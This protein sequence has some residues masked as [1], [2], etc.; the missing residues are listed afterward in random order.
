[1]RHP[2]TLPPEPGKIKVHIW[3]DGTRYWNL[4]QTAQQ[5]GCTRQAVDA[6]AKRN[7]EACV[8]VDGHT[9]IREGAK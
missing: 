2:A 6:W 3:R 1:M 5:R 7:P 8:E 9:Y 4:V